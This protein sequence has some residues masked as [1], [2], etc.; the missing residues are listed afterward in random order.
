MVNSAGG[1]PVITTDLNVTAIRSIREKFKSVL[2]IAAIGGWNGPHPPPGTSGKKWCDLFVDFNRELGNIFDGID[3]DLEGHDDRSSLT[4][5]FSMDTLDVMADFSR[6]AKHVHGLTVTMAPA[7]SYLDSMA[8][9]VDDSQL[10]SLDLNILPSAWMR[11]ER[12]RS[13]INSSGF[14]HA[15]RQCYAYVLKKAGIDTFDWV[16][17]QLY[18][19]FSRYLHETTRIQPESLD[20]TEAIFRRADAFYRGYDVNNMPSYGKVNIKIPP[21]KLV[22][23]VA[24]GWADGVKFAK[25]S[26]D[27]VAQ[28]QRLLL[29]KY[30]P[31]GLFRGAMFWTIEE[32]GNDGIFMA[33]SLVTALKSCKSS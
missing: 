10:F 3:W 15:G 22:I 25:I 24:N 30:G 32:E 19:G 4:S 18:E 29:E 2:H 33:S 17:I 14:S 8:T 31:K 1:D 27:D 16:A 23:G 6:E 28:A 26:S 12:D 11:S 20:S 7:E 21:H 13:I 5:K 9:D